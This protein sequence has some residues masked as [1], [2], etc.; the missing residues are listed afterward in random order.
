MYKPRIW[1]GLP[2]PQDHAS[3]TAIESVSFYHR[4]KRTTD[5]GEGHVL[6]EQLVGP[7]PSRC[8]YLVRFTSETLWVQ[9]DDLRFGRRK[10]STG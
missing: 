5:L 9:S 3:M 4:D 10:R 8:Y 6:A 2:I 7:H 1:H